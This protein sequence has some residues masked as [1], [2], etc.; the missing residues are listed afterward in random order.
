MQANVMAATA[1]W[2]SHPSV[3]RLWQRPF[4]EAKLA[5]FWAHQ[6]RST[7]S[8]VLDVGCGPGTNA[9]H[10]AELDYL[11]VDLSPEYVA[12]ARRSHGDRFAVVDVCRDEIPGA[13]NFDLI[14]VNSL[15]HHIATPDVEQM[16]GRLALRLA[17][18][19]AIHILDLVQ[20]DGW[21]AARLLARWDRGDFPRPLAEWRSLFAWS[22]EV[23]IFEPYSLPAHGP[24]LWNMVYFKGRRR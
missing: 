2:M 5:P 22:F 15:L 20:P 12:H 3:Y 9:H 21:G 6:G 18:G 4:A 14:L 11:G 1:N 8:R 13:E 7:V 10:F 24:T 16:L 23:D 19:G 17:D